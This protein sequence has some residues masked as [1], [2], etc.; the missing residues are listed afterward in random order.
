MQKFFI[1][2]IFMFWVFTGF[3]QSF[4]QNKNIKGLN[5]PSNQ[6]LSLCQDDAGRIWVSTAKGIYY[7]D[8]ITTYGIPDSIHQVLQNRPNT[9]VDTD[10][11][12]YMFNTERTKKIYYVSDYKWDE[13]VIPGP[14]IEKVG[15]IGKVSVSVAYVNGNKN[16]FLVVPGFIAVYDF[17]SSK[18]DYRP[19]DV[20]TLGDFSSFYQSGDTT[21]FYFEKIILKLYNSEI[22]SEENWSDLLDGPVYKVVLDAENTFYFLGHGKLAKGKEFKKPQDIIHSGFAQAKFGNHHYF[23]LKIN[24]GKVFYYFNSHLYRHS[25]MDRLPLLISAEENLRIYLIQALLI[26]RE[27]IIWIGS[28]RGLVNVPTLRFQNY[29]VRDGLLDNEVTAI[30]KDKPQKFYLG[31]NNGIQ[32]WEN[33]VLKTLDI[34]DHLKGTSGNRINNFTPTKKGIYFSAGQKGVGLINLSNNQVTYKT[35]PNGQ[36][37]QFTSIID[38]HLYILAGSNVY[39]SHITGNNVFA[40]D[41][42]STIYSGQG[43]GNYLRKI[44]KLSD[45]KIIYLHSTST[46]GIQEGLVESQHYLRVG[47]YDFLEI[48]EGVLLATEE[49]LKI[50]KQGKIEVFSVNNKTVDRPI[51]SLLQDERGAVWMGTDKG[52][53]VLYNGYITWFDSSRGLV[54]DEVNRGAFIRGNPG[55][56]WIGTEEGISIYRQ[57]E[58]EELLASPIV[59]IE[60]IRLLTDGEQSYSFSNIP[61]N[62][63]NIQIDYLAVSFMQQNNLH[64]HYRL[65]GLS[66]KWETVID[67]RSKQLIFENLPPGTYHLELKASLGGQFESPVVI[68]DGFIIDQPYYYKPIFIFFVL[69]L[70]LALGFILN[71]L[72]NQFRN[73]MLLRKTISQKISEI[74]L[75]EEQFRNVWNSSKDGLCL[76]IISGKIIAINPAMTKLC[77]VPA[78][79]LKK[80]HLGE[81]FSDPNFYKNQEPYILESLHNHGKAGMTKELTMPFK[82]GPK[83]IELYST[84][85]DIKHGNDTVMLSVFRDITEKKN[86]EIQL[87]L[88]K[89]K[90]EESNQLKS[91]FLSNMSHEIRTPLN[92]ILGSAENLIITNQD[93]PELLSGLEIILESGER[94]L[95]T[96]NSILDMSKIE[97]RTMETRM[98]KTNINDFISKILMPLKAAAMKKGLLLTA[99]FETKSFVAPIDKAS[100]D[101]IL[102]NIVSNAIK[103]S[104]KGLIQVKIK[105]LDQSL[106]IQVQDEGIGMSEDFLL[107][108][109]QPFQQ[110]SGGYARK[111]EGSGL[112][113]SITKSLMDMLKGQIYITSSKG[114]GT[115][116]TITL[117]LDLQITKEQ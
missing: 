115:T 19:Y 51:F 117:P 44:D 5:L 84:M 100:L 86:S 3:S 17:S 96:I 95:K 98:E 6:I 110:E 38:D 73:E 69:V 87:R 55:R 22:S 108:I 29:T 71:T 109:F 30:Y 42:T 63:N 91:R 13:L 28:Q 74:Q 113:L 89:E 9:Y 83:T 76:S 15:S 97:S 82:N 16:L 101:M 58:D 36:G 80:G 21:Y 35:A 25:S 107:K 56:I 99:K 81:M 53:Y 18:W 11:V 43:E 24:D 70:F 105:L 54:G 37:V 104:N 1:S 4:Q 39:K 34:F 62:H 88:A 72:L 92:G 47:G 2:L 12:I 114:K 68:S 23:D 32:L 67:P 59:K 64:I 85:V 77:G 79:E 116:V 8:G 57:D 102:N 50:Y 93:K 75:A 112:G 78:K 66:D 41:V 103:Y 49:G 20:P 10:G 31:F 65:M 26:D 48:E 27:D 45:G 111:F 40:Q 14:V 61:Y 46:S 106:Y 33:N 60:N 94:L 52:V 7:S 90:A